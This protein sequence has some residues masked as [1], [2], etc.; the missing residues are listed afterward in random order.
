LRPGLL[1]DARLAEVEIGVA[2]LHRELQ[3]IVRLRGRAVIVFTVEDD[4][5]A[6]DG[7]DAVARV[8]GTTNPNVRW[9]PTNVDSASQSANVVASVHM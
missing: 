7:R 1:V 5:Q 2:I 6:R 8:I 3:L 9:S 4:A